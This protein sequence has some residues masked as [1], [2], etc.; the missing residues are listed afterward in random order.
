ME[1][2]VV[3][4]NKPFNFTIE[5]NEVFENVDGDPLTFSI[6]TSNKSQIPTWLQFNNN[7]TTL[8]FTGTPLSIGNTSIIL[9]AKD[10]CNEVAQTE[11]TISSINPN[12]G[13][14]AWVTPVAITAAGVLSLAALLGAAYRKWLQPRNH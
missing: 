5:T 7:D 10:W 11:F 13:S 2:Q 14:N 4:I 12:I 9:S 6:Q 8:T 1:H 3:E